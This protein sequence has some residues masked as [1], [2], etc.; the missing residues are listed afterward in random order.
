MMIAASACLQL[1]VVAVSVHGPAYIR[2]SSTPARRSFQIYSSASESRSASDDERGALPAQGGTSRGL[3][4]DLNSEGGLQV[5]LDDQIGPLV[6]TEDGQYRTITNWPDMTEKEKEVTMR[7]ITKRNA[8]RLK[9]LRGGAMLTPTGS[10]RSSVVMISA[11]A[12]DVAS[13]ASASGRFTFGEF[14]CAY[15]HKP[16]AKGFEKEPPLLLVHPIGIGLASWFWIPF[17]EAWEGAEVFAPD[18]VG[19]GASDAWDPSKQGLFIPLDYVRQLETLWRDRI[20]P[21]RQV[22]VVC[23]GG[24]APVAVMLASRQSDTWDG[25]KAGEALGILRPL[26]FLRLGDSG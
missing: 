4:L 11:A 26:P 25:P 22:N 23:Q 20:G 12:P 15:R 10:S 8:E 6:V 5:E 13:S 7:R 24:L 17:M 3:N 19:C 9:R 18:F 14:T 21:E 16:A 1:G 2:A